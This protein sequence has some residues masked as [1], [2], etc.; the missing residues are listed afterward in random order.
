MNRRML[1]AC[2]SILDKFTKA[3]VKEVIEVL[4][5]FNKCNEDVRASCLINGCKNDENTVRR[6]IATYRARVDVGEI[7]RMS[8]SA[9]YSSPST[10]TCRSCGR[11]L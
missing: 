4:T 8:K 2:H 3:E 5:E 10:S 9:S 6:R 1:V 11:P 7:R